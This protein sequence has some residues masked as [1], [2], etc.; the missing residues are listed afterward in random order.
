M[1]RADREVRLPNHPVMITDR[2][3]MAHGLEA[4]SPYMDHKLVEFASRLPHSVKI[5]GTT[6]R[7]IQ[8]KLAERYLPPS[9]LRRPKQGFAS[10]LPYLL[11]REFSQLHRACLK[12][13]RLVEEK[14]LEPRTLERLIEEHTRGRAD[15]GH[16]L[17]LLINAELWYRVMIDGQKSEELRRDLLAERANPNRSMGASPTAAAVEPL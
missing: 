5:R 7:F 2:I 8:R 1:L 17:W 9:V 13:S 12:D 14:I 15:H 10:A 4:R 11:Q 6:L 3:C 16:R